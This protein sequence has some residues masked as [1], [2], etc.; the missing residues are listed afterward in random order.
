MKPPRDPEKSNPTKWSERYG[1]YKVPGMG[2]ALMEKNR[3]D[4]ERKRRG[5]YEG[6]GLRDPDARP[7]SGSYA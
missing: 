3:R 5:R 4:Q 6:R 2:Q 1:R 7:G